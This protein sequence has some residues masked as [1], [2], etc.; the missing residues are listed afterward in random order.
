MIRW[1]NL[2]LF[3]GFEACEEGILAAINRNFFILDAFVQMRIQDFVT[4]LPEDP[5]PGDV[6]ILET[7]DYIYQADPGSIMVWDGNDWNEFIPK[8]GWSGWVISEESYYHYEEGAW[9]EG[10]SGGGGGALAA[11][12]AA[13]TDGM[14]QLSVTF[15]ES[16]EVTNYVISASFKNTVDDAADQQFIL[17]KIIAQDDLGFTLLFNQSIFGVNNSCLWAVFELP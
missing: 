11:G 1:E 3:G 10:G 16:I 4:V 13:L 5:E 17:Y 12:Q 2:E 7:D 14:T 6:Y 15:L 9:V 8:D